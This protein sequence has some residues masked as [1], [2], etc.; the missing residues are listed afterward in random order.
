MEGM[1]TVKTAAGIE[2]DGP[3]DEERAKNLVMNLRGDIEKLRADLHDAKEEA[4]KVPG[5]EAALAD[6]KAEIEVKSGELNTL[7]VKTAKHRILSERGLP[8]ALE[9]ALNG[10]SEADWV[11]MAD[12]LGELRNSGSSSTGAYHDPV[13]SAVDP[14]LTEDALRLQQ[15]RQIFGD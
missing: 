11:R 6:A 4:G 12:L 8:E 2:W 1:D 3:F 5:L 13:Q 9:D 10:D 14:G 15:A 7:T